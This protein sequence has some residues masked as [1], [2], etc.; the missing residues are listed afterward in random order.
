M[1]RVVTPEILDS[2]DCPPH[3]V[4]KSLR[5]LSRIN[6]WFGGIATT[7][8]M[9][10]RVAAATGKKHF[11]V[12]EV[13]AGHGEVPRLA[14]QQLAR[15]G[16]TLDVTLLDLKRSHLLPG[17]HSVVADALALPFPDGSFDL[18]SCSL[19]AHHLE[20]EELARFSQEAMRVGRI[21]LLVNDLVRHPLHLAL[22]Y[23]GWPLMRSHVSRMDGVASVRRAY[24]LEEMQDILTNAAAPRRKIEL[25]Q[26]YLF[27]MGVILWKSISQQDRANKTK[28]QKDFESATVQA[29]P[30]TRKVK[31]HS[32]QL[33]C[34]SG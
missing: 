14:A 13:A 30:V 19:F 23:A 27:R 3:E 9:I 20:P 34:A 31:A 5:D 29:A 15:I 32:D 10:E 33:K 6:H 1:R 28:N 12:L 21:A 2:D 18:V 24:T 4:E 17:N 22:V 25:S 26:H 16:I 7:R 8:K 11:S